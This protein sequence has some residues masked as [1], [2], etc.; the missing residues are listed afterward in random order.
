MIKK[1]QH[2]KSTHI[3]YFITAM[4]SISLILTSCG[5]TTDIDTNVT[6]QT[7]DNSN[8]TII[9][10]N[11]TLETDNITEDEITTPEPEANSIVEESIETTENTT[12]EVSELQVHFIDVG[13][14]D[15]TLI[16]C[17]SEAMLIDA[18]D[19]DQGTKIQNYLQKQGIESLK[20]VICTHPDA[21]HIGGM[22]VILYKFNCETIFMT[23]EQKDTNTYR[24][25][26]DTMENK[27]YKNTLPVV[28]EQYS[29][30]DAEFTILAPSKLCDTSNDNSIAIILMHGNN[31]FLFT[32]DAEEEEENSILNSG[33]TIDADVYK[34]GHHGSSSSS[35]DK[36]LN[37]VSPMYAVISCAEGNAYGHPHAETLNSLRSMGV[38][39]FRTDE[40]GSI[41][42]T[43][44]GTGITWNC[45][46]SDTWQAGENVQNSANSNNTDNTP[47]DTTAPNTDSVTESTEVSTPTA[48]PTEV[49]TEVPTETPVET[50]IETPVEIPSSITYICNINTMKFHYPSCSSVDQM[51][52]KNKLPVNATRDELIS[53]GYE[54]CKRCNP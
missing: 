52:E 54:P 31:K 39:V 28:G 47:N 26:I 42:A 15:C 41:I 24:D 29:L 10:D 8:E 13:Q 30:G 25:V 3:K 17:D 51:S 1:F 2:F 38:Q 48:T 7:V 9:E 45:S 12:K 21:D 11:G 36:F 19:N 37:A 5:S 50:V 49:P 27:G 44:D 53:Q 20:Y 34:V 4:L 14:G 35:S 32:G 43:S 22:D 46:P 6:A 33:I 16:I 18:G 23:D 40:Q